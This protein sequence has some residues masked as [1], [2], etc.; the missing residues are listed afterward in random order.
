MKKMMQKL[1]ENRKNNKGFTLVELI[2][3][4]AIIAVLAAVLAPQYIRYVERSRQGVDANTLSE[5]FHIV[6]VE[7]GLITHTAATTVTIAGSGAIA[8]TFPAANL[9]QVTATVGGTSVSFKS[10]AAAA[11]TLY[12]I[13]IDATGK[14]EW[15]AESKTKLDE[16][17]K[18]ISTTTSHIVGTT[19]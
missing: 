9:T 6:E 10:A 3:V 8:G 13:N 12:T 1:Q 4:I 16:L 14:V 2:I 5:V 19:P 15:G 18:G 7:S 17:Q 11:R